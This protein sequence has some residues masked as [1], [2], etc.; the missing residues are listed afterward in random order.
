M[1]KGAGGMR[2]IKKLIPLLLIFIVLFLSSC[3]K[4]EFNPSEDTC[5][6]G[7]WVDMKNCT[8]EVDENGTTIYSS[9]Y[10]DTRVK[11][12]GAYGRCIAVNCVEWTK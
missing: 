4:Q 12:C 5:T 10:I 8:C 6:Q 9:P 2:Y 1:G 3:A 11:M 7:E